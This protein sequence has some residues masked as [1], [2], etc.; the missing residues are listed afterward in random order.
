MWKGGTE[1]R[2]IRATSEQWDYLHSKVFGKKNEETFFFSE[3]VLHK[4]YSS[5]KWQ[6]LHYHRHVLLFLFVRQTVP[7]CWKT[8]DTDLGFF[9]SF[10]REK[11]II[12]FFRSDKIEKKLARFGSEEKC[13][14]V[15]V[16]HANGSSKLICYIL[17]MIMTRLIL[18]NMTSLPIKKLHNF[19]IAFRRH[20]CIGSL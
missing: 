15:L 1:L 2:L 5:C 9:L 20:N 17:H 16:T 11:K 12:V 13:R 4:S 18:S 10:I 7:H 8:I 19:V 6:D 3:N 14:V